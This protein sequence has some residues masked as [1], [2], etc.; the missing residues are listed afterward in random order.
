MVNQFRSFLPAVFISS[1][2]VNCEVLSP[3]TIQTGLLLPHLQSA[4]TGLSS[5]QITNTNLHK[6][7][8]L[9]KCLELKCAK[10]LDS[11]QFLKIFQFS[12][13]YANLSLTIN[14]SSLTDDLNIYRLN[15]FNPYM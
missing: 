6:K 8:L 11:I 13:F 1:N 4:L 3:Y 10:T 2:L 12:L 5:D 14:L 7:E 15:C 9:K